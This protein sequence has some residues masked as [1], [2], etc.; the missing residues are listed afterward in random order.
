MPRRPT[1]AETVVGFFEKVGQNT[2]EGAATL[3]KINAWIGLIVFVPIGLAM[4][5]LGIVKDFK[6]DPHTP[7]APN[8]MS[9]MAIRGLLIGFGSL[10]FFGS[11]GNL[12]LTRKSTAWSAYEGARMFTRLFK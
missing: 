5:A 4:I 3:G 9:P 8:Q 6:P 7:V 12:V 1:S 10:L 2:Y 11:I